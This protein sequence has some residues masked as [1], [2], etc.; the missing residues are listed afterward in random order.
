MSTPSAD[1]SAP[2]GSPRQDAAV[3]DVIERHLVAGNAHDVAAI[4]AT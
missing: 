4:L 1:P 3:P 2:F